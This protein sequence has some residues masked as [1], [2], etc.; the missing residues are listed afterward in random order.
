MSKFTP[1]PWRINRHGFETSYLCHEFI[2]GDS[3][4][5]VFGVWHPENHKEQE[6]NARL[7]AAAPEL[8]EALKDLLD[9]C[10]CEN[11]C[12]PDDM[13]C[14]TNKARAALAKVEG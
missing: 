11:N 4:I 9:V 2:E 14:A 6:A 1:G 8:Y 7:I 10:H 13:T 3:G 5:A 12:A